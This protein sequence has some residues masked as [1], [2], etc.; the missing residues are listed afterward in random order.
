MAVDFSERMSRLTDSQL[1]DVMANRGDY[2]PEAIAAA[3]AEIERRG[4]AEALGMCPGVESQ[5]VHSGAEPSTNRKRMGP[6]LTA[7]CIFVVISALVGKFVVLED[8]R[9][10]NAQRI[11][12]ALAE[13]ADQENADAPR[14]IDQVTRFEGVS[15][16]SS[17]LSYHLTLLGDIPVPRRSALGEELKANVTKA[18]NGTPELRKLLDK[19]VVFEYSYYTEDR[20][21]VCRFVVG[22]P[23]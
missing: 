13:V 17:G 21:L 7:A 2:V 18:L 16:S 9:R 4:G 1:L 22:R 19:G 20:A 3:Q 5:P 8:A 10:E 11:G 14:M 6:I 15:S 23:D 12:S